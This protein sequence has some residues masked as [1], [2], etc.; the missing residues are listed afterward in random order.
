MSGAELNRTSINP[1]NLTTSRGKVA[2]QRGP[3][4]TG[5][6]VGILAGLLPPTRFGGIFNNKPISEQS[7]PLGVVAEAAT[8]AVAGAQ[9]VINNL[10]EASPS[11]PTA[12]ST[13]AETTKQQ[14]KE[15]TEDPNTIFTEQ[16]IVQSVALKK[17]TGDTSNQGQTRLPG[18]E[19]V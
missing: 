9:K 8:A 5:K 17:P 1:S 12:D 2:E 15:A 14:V 7:T 6:G 11:K 16:S 10:S 3:M 13:I 19:I 18:V 4:P